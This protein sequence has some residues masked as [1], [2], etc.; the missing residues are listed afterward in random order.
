MSDTPWLPPDRLHLFKRIR[1]L[2]GGGVGDVWLY[3]DG[4]VEAAIKLLRHPQALRQFRREATL[5]GEFDSDHIPHLLDQDTENDAEAVPWFAME[6]VAGQRITE[7]CEERSAGID[8]RL[9]IFVD[10][11]RA[12]Q[13][14][15]DHAIFH[16]DLKP[17]NV[18]VTENGVAKVLDFGSAHRFTILDVSARPTVAF[19]SPGHR[20]PEQLLN[21]S[22]SAR[23]DIFQLGMLLFELLAGQPYVPILVNEM[24]AVTSDPPISVSSIARVTGAITRADREQWK[25]LDALCAAML[26]QKPEDRIPLASLLSDIQNYKVGEPLALRK[27]TEP[28]LSRLRKSARR[29]SDAV[30]VGAVLVCA[31]IV[32]TALYI[33]SLRKERADALESR[34]IA[35][36]VVAYMT[37]DLLQGGDVQFGPTHDMAV[38]SVLDRGARSVGSLKGA[39]LQATTLETLGKSYQSLGNPARAATLIR[40]A[41]AIRRRSPD[42]KSLAVAHDLNLLADVLTDQEKFDEAEKTARDALALSQGARP[43]DNPE[44]GRAEYAVAWALYQVGKYK[45]ALPMAADSVRVFQRPNADQRLYADSLS[46]VGQLYFRLED[47]KTAMVWHSRVLALERDLHGDRHPGYAN[48]LVF[49]GF[50][51]GELGRFSEAEK[52]MREALAIRKEWFGPDHPETAKTAHYLAQ[53]LNYETA[54]K[55]YLEAETLMKNTIPVLDRAYGQ[56]NL[57]VS[58]V[59]GDMAYSASQDGRVNDAINYE[60]KALDIT[61]KKLGSNHRDTATVLGN[62]A[63]DYCK[64]G[65]YTNGEADFREAL[66]I[67]DGLGFS[68]SVDAL[69]DHIRLGRCLWLSGRLSE[70]ADEIKRALAT[71]RG[72]NPTNEYWIQTALEELILLY[73]KANAADQVANFQKQLDDLKAKEKQ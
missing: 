18:L 62:V 44:F 46:M 11:C 57:E 14:A 15:H 25:D 9:L 47:F 38:S 28:A 68:N 63:G 48:S 58:G 52:N 12:A 39:N 8:E 22:V 4:S 23:T 56:N 55:G 30:R 5:L 31:L 32:T 6:Y 66:A 27:H 42:A 45:E 33:F 7:Y 3:S 10:V 54:R 50:C 73:Q 70:G 34:E 20:A 19:N 71:L 40:Q 64:G 51:L 53:M 13:H 37:D 49:L 41:L 29:H 60:E 59:L 35:Q 67:F 1:R 2:G 43:R 69:A 36:S 17:S 65:Q 26:Q 61:R 16:L 24:A 72:M 21:G